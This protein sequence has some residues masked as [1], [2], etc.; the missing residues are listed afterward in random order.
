MKTK[1][2]HNIHGIFASL[3]KHYNLI[4]RLSHIKIQCS[5]PCRLLQ[6]GSGCDCS[7]MCLLSVIFFN[8][9]QCCHISSFDYLT[10]VHVSIFF[11]MT[12]NFIMLL[13][14]QGKFHSIFPD[15]NNH[16]IIKETKKRTKT[17]YP[18]LL[19]I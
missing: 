19:I 9:E 2:L 17:Q 12:I 10:C 16:P 3:C 8:M 4:P 13:S 7:D 15:L 11:I 18:L 1:S 5:G 14:Y 6:S